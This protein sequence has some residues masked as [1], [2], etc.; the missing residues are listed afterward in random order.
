MQKICKKRVADKN[1]CCKGWMITFFDV[2]CLFV[3]KNYYL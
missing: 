1:L 2:I 3:G